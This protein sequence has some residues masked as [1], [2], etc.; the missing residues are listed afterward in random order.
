MRRCLK[1]EFD[2]LAEDHPPVSDRI[3]GVLFVLKTLAERLGIVAALGQERS[4]KRALF[5]VLARVAH[6]GSRLSAVRWAEEQ[7]VAEVLGVGRFNE[8]DLYHALDWLAQHQ[9]HLENKLYR[10]DVQ[11]NTSRP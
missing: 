4:A 2:G 5:L 8:D 10:H 6:Q 11:R 7:A 1:G 9:P 3:F